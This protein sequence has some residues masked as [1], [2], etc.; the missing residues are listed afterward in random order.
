MRN[1]CHYQKMRNES[2]RMNVHTIVVSDRSIV[3]HRESGDHLSDLIP[4]VF[5]LQYK[6]EVRR[7]KKNTYRLVYRIAI[8]FEKE[9][10]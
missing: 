6:V 2:G 7:Q 8:Q 4:S 10:T 1:F 9:I 5:I 3:S